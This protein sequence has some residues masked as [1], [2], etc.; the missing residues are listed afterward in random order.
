MPVKKP[1]TVFQNLLDSL[2]E[3]LDTPPPPAQTGSALT[4]FNALYPDAAAQVP[5]VVKQQQV[6]NNYFAEAVDPATGLVKG[7]PNSDADP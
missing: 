6:A 3:A 4:L 7:I 1:K 5:A 2:S